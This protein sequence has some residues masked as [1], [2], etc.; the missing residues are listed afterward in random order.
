MEGSEIKA[1]V[2]GH[3]FKT[4]NDS[5]TEVAAEGVCDL[6][7]DVAKSEADI[8]HLIANEACAINKNVGD[9]TCE[10][11]KSINDAESRIIKNDTDIAHRNTI[12]LNSVERDLQNQVLTNRSVLIKEINDKEDRLTDRLERYNLSL[13]DQMR[14][15]E[16]RNAE[17]FCETKE[18]IREKSET[19]LRQLGKDKYDALKDELDEERACRRKC[20]S[21]N[22]VALLRSELTSIKQMV[23]SQSEDYKFISKISQFGA[24]N[25]AIPA[26]TSNKS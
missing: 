1:S 22:V 23:N 16:M 17:K 7:R 20:D 21:D 5:L 3:G 18:L 9:G 11:L 10:T 2:W 14:D 15:F 25:A 19:I 26:Q 4:G 12:H 24:G 13:K 8:K 6:R